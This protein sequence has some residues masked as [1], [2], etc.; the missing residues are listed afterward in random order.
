MM[1]RLISNVGIIQFFLLPGLFAFFLFNFSYSLEAQEVLSAGRSYRSLALGNT[2]VASATDSAAL[3][4]NPAILANVEGW[5]FDYA[6]WTV[7]ASQGF[8]A[9]DAG[10]MLAST[11]L[12]YINRNG[13]D[14][15]KKETFLEQENPYLRANAGMNIFIN[16]AKKGYTLAG[17]YLQEVVYTTTVVDQT[18]MIYQ[19]DDIIQ[20]VGF[21]IPIGAG[22]LVLGVAGN[23]INRRI[24][25]DAT[26]D[27][28]PNWSDNYIGTGY[29]IG[30]LYR[31]A[32]AL[33][34][35]WGL[36]VQNS[37]DIKYGDSDFEDPQQIALGVSINHDLGLIRL[38]PAIDIRQINA[39]TGKTNTIHAGLEVGIFPNRTGGNYLTYRVGYNQGYSSQG[40]ELN[41][42]NHSM[43]IGY[44]QYGE[45]IGQDTE[46]VES[47][48]AVAYFS[49]GF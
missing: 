5:W 4:Y 19:R 33:H 37:G 20:K 10:L 48:R 11:N 29:D 47:R 32:T 30:L 43:I 42:F 15:E 17:S 12:P 26:T 9:A 22:Q 46:K 7:E 21:S 3:Y 44:T 40:I 36:V 39:E 18:T 23:R 24:A 41:F 27:S 6:A 8:A 34:V 25:Q 16:F 1:K 49:L 2:G 13:I 45:E 14:D 35:T 31:M 38:F 28:I